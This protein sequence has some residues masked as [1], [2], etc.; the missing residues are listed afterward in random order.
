MLIA[1]STNVAWHP[2]NVK[3]IFIYRSDKPMEFRIFLPEPLIK[4][5]LTPVRVSKLKLDLNYFF[6]CTVYMHMSCLFSHYQKQ[7]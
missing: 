6:M 7:E 4:T 5:Y 1:P 3:E 2:E